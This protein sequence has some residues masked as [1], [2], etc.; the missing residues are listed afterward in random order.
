MCLD[1]LT[2]FCEAVLFLWMVQLNQSRVAELKASFFM[3]SFCCV[4]C[5]TLS[6]GLTVLA[7]A[8]RERR[9]FS[10]SGRAG[11]CIKKCKLAM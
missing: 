11:K 8:F 6:L 3:P 7:R 10:C 5:S 1:A 2:D 9:N 4:L